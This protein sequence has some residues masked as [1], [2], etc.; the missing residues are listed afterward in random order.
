MT[1]LSFKSEMSQGK[2]KTLFTL[3]SAHDPTTTE[4][5]RIGNPNVRFRDLWFRRNY[6]ARVR[7]PLSLPLP[8][9]TTNTES[10]TSSVSTDS[11][12]DTSSTRDSATDNTSLMVLDSSRDSMS[13][14][15]T[16][17]TTTSSEGTEDDVLLVW[18]SGSTDVDDP[19]LQE[20]E[21]EDESE[22]SSGSSLEQ[23]P[24]FIRPRN[25][26]SIMRTRRFRVFRRS[27]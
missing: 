19:S 9:R 15:R 7:Y 5:P 17:T 14:S 25:N 21:N 20:N 13:S 24:R 3:T 4:A 1:H 27:S 18:D 26:A 6:Q 11:S 12:Q 8:S 16:T 10:S 22:E 23:T 2:D